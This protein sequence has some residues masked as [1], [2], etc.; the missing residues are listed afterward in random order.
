MKILL[1]G[2]DG[3][4]GFELQHSLAKLGQVIALGRGEGDFANIDGLAGTVRTISPDVI[5]NAAAYTAVDKA[6]TEADLAHL[7]NAEAPAVL[8]REAKKIGAWLVHYSTDYVFD[9]SGKKPWAENDNT[10]PLNVYGKTKRDGDEAI[11]ASGCKYLLFRTSW[12]YSPRGNNFPKTML[13][14]AKER[15]QLNVVNDQFG[16]PTGAG[17]IADITAQALHAVQQK[18]ELGGLYHLA[19]NGET[20]WHTYALYVLD[21][22][23]NA[24]VELKTA[25]EN[26]VSI[27]S[28]ALSSTARRPHNSRLD[29]TKLTNAFGFQL[30]HWQS[31]VT[32]AMTELFGKAS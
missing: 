30:P 20:S 2:K 10:S 23:R 29:T 14:L 27:P 25:R 19:A 12:V 3:Q 28:S 31:G 24:G 21:M 6:E 26:I 32:R 18:P 5:V 13:R 15:E 17:L 8:A 7:I 11:F 16:A 4:V 1:F 9:G 22:A